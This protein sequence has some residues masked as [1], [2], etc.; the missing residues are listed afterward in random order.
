MNLIDAGCSKVRS[1]MLFQERSSGS[2]SYDMDS[3]QSFEKSRSGNN[4]IYYNEDFSDMN[5]VGLP[6]NDIIQPFRLVVV[7]KKLE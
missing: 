7:S 4:E 1:I 5:N 3:T 6:L 2:R